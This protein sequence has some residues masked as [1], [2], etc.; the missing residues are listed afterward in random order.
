MAASEFPPESIRGVVAEVMG[1]LREKGESVCVAETVSLPFCFCFG[2]LA[3]WD[4]EDLFVFF[5]FG[6][7]VLCFGG[8]GGGRRNFWLLVYLGVLKFPVRGLDFFHASVCGA[9]PLEVP[10]KALWDGTR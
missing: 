6:L 3:V 1:L 10:W 2:W 7:L 4:L 5:L 8:V 9:S